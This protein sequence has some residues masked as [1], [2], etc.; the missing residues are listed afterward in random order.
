MDACSHGTR[1]SPRLGVL[2]PLLLTAARGVVR[3][4]LRDH[5][6]A[7]GRKATGL[8]FAEREHVHRALVARARQELRVRT[9]ANAVDLRSVRAASTRT[10]PKATEANT[11]SNSDLSRTY[12][13]ST[14]NDEPKLLQDLSALRVKHAD[15]RALVRCRREARAL[16]VQANLSARRCEC[17]VP[18][19][20]AQCAAYLRELGLMRSDERRLAQVVEL[21]PDS[22]TAHAGAR[23]H[24]VGRARA[25]RT[26]TLGVR[27]RLD[28][29]HKLQVSCTDQRE[30][31]RQDST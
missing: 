19:S 30:A 1:S 20:V 9:E 12:N 17:Q 11:V 6:R 25:Q 5:R 26:Q 3:R 18:S 16:Q 22:A 31:C 7:V 2:G 14:T 13:P 24:R 15:Q 28:V 10:R 23:E 21:D 8:V 29:V 27:D 4:V